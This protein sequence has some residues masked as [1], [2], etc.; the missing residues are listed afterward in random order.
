MKI[1]ENE[2]KIS[3]H[4]SEDGRHDK[5]HTLDNGRSLRQ[6]ILLLALAC[7]LHFKLLGKVKNML[8]SDQHQSKIR[9][10]LVPVSGKV[11]LASV[12]LSGELMQEV[13]QI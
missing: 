9:F 11:I 5:R 4:V 8:N 1:F 12:E 7:S 3:Y 13:H 10:M 6:L 2:E